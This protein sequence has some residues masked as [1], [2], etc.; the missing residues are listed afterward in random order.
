MAPSDEILPAAP[1]D[2]PAT[3][4]ASSADATAPAAPLPA[5]EGTTPTEAPVSPGP[6]LTQAEAQRLDALAGSLAAEL[7]EPE[8]QPLPAPPPALSEREQSNATHL[9]NL[10]ARGEPQCPVCGNALVRSLVPG[11][12]P[13][14]PTGPWCCSWDAGHDLGVSAPTVEA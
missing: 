11:D 2:A 5:P 8:K 14:T 1:P 13:G 3:A 6:E 12:Y 4:T 9:Q 7:K 10:E